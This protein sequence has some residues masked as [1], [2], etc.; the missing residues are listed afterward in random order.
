MKMV[1]DYVNEKCGTKWHK[2][3]ARE[4]LRSYKDSYKKVK[5]QFEDV[6]GGKF[7][8]TEDELAKGLTIDK[9]LEKLCY[10][11]SRMDQLFGNK[12]NV[13]PYSTMQSGLSMLITA[14]GSDSE[15]EEDDVV[16]KHQG[17]VADIAVDVAPVADIAVKEVDNLV[18]DCELSAKSTDTALNVS[19]PLTATKKD[20]KDKKETCPVPDDLKNLCSSFQPIESMKTC[21]TLLS[22]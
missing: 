13:K 21:R 19:P 22:F 18:E 8:L 14:I 9:K 20:K 5:N 4:T 1:V 3:K 6:S 7:C 11:Y 2:D 17:Y 12:Q 16:D 10:G 15:D